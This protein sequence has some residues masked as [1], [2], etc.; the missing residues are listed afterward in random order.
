M[1][2]F[3]YAVIGMQV[4]LLPCIVSPSKVFQMQLVTVW[5]MLTPF[6]DIWKDCYR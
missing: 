3:I 4:G 6:A 5:P 2:F 1:I